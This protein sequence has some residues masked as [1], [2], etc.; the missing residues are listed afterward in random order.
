MFAAN[1]VAWWA[2]QIRAGDEVR[3]P[4]L[5]GAPARPFRDRVARTSRARSANKPGDARE[6]TEG[7]LSW[8]FARYQP[9]LVNLVKGKSFAPLRDIPAPVAC[10]PA[11]ARS[12]MGRLQ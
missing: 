7:Y 3:W 9:A 11:T 12:D 10:T 6:G 4:Y 5:T 8:P 2:P 1:T